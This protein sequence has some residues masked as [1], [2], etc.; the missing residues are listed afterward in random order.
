MMHTLPSSRHLPGASTSRR[1]SQ[2]RPVTA[3]CLA[4]RVQPRARVSVRASAEDEKPAEFA[5]VSLGAQ[6]SLDCPYW[7]QPSRQLTF[8][9]HCLAEQAPAKPKTPFGEMLSYYLAMEPQ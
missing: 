8:S 6:M 5:L 2:H 7:R 4:R 1:T 3:P 9:M